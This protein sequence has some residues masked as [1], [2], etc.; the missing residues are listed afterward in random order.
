MCVV[1]REEGTY[2]VREAVWG[3]RGLCGGAETDRKHMYVFAGTSLA[4]AE[5]RRLRLCCSTAA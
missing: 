4:Y 1:E 2:K 3:E 5:G